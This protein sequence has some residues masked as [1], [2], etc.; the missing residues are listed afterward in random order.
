MANTFVDYTATASQLDPTDAAYGFVFNFPYLEDTHVVVEVAGVQLDASNFSLQTTP[1]SRVLIA[2]GASAGQTVRVKR[3][4]DST[5]DLVDFVNGSV[6]S[7]TELDRAY[8]HNRYLNE[9]LADLNAQSL[10]KEV[11]GTAWD[12]K[13]FR[14]SNVANPVNVQDASTK[15]YV[16]SQISKTITGASTEPLK[17]AFTGNG[18]DTVFTFN[19][20]IDLAGDTLYEVAI[21]GVLQEPTTAYAIDAD[22]ETITFTSAPPNL[23]SIV[24]VK[25]GYSVP[26]S[27]G[28]IMTE[29]ERTKLESIE[30]GA[31][32]FEYEESANDGEHLIYEGLGSKVVKNK[33]LLVKAAASATTEQLNFSRGS[34]LERINASFTDIINNFYRFSYVNSNN[35]SGANSTPTLGNHGGRD[36]VH[37]INGVGVPIN[38]EAGWFQNT[39]NEISQPLNSLS[40]IGFASNE[41]YDTYDAMVVAKSTGGDDDM[42][43]WVIALNRGAP[44]DDAANSPYDS[45]ISVHRAVNT[46]T[47]GGSGVNVYYNFR[48]PGSRRIATNQD[49][50]TDSFPLAN[51]GWGAYD[52][53]PF[54]IE[55]RPTYIKIWAI[56]NA[57]NA[58]SWDDSSWVF[59]AEID[60][61]DDPDLT[62]FQNPGAWGLMACSQSDCSWGDLFVNAP[63]SNAST[64]TPAPDPALSDYVFDVEA[65]KAYAYEGGA[66][67]EKSNVSIHD[68]VDSGQLLYDTT[69]RTL[70]VKDSGTITKLISPRSVF[71]ERTT[72]FTVEYT[73]DSNVIRADAGCSTI[74]FNGNYGAGFQCKILNHSGASVTLQSAGDTRFKDDVATG[75]LTLADNEMAECVGNGLNS[76]NNISVTISSIS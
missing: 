28:V 61:T 74:S 18:A 11:A 54:K 73:H 46:G 51:G 12:A 62:Q 17:Y 34:N 15:D 67:V 6:L 21:D 16:D 50:F 7:E 29:E 71:D 38:E 39:N 65:N 33:K 72:N 48:L 70:S 35:F 41:K 66:W 59:I 52:G 5:T 23:S 36:A 3:V 1:D 10:Q 68:Y 24:V 53:C 76:G 57:E 69:S 63:A 60:L 45:Y 42:I 2:S 55:R 75:T 26:V 20:G 30:V 43:G 25:R 47:G 4:S 31:S 32:N 19:P 22:A 8:Q 44:N 14:I 58:P 64:V 56:D 9:E 37:D 27:G 49:D 13:G 40:A